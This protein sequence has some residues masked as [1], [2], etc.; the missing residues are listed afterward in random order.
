MIYV[1]EIIIKPEGCENI[2]KNAISC[3]T[4]YEIELMRSLLRKRGT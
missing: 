3:F 4:H 1:I 2:L